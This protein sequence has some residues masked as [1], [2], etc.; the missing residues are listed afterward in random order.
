[1]TT[2]TTFGFPSNDLVPFQVRL[3]R[4]RV[5][6]EFIRLARANK[7]VPIRMN[8]NLCVCVCMLAR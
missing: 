8:V 3:R 1:M 2:T 4:T 5:R 7:N 6:N